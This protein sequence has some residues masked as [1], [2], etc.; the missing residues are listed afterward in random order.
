MPADTSDTS[1]GFVFSVGDVLWTVVGQFRA[2]EVGPQPFG[3]V[4]LGCISRQQYHL[5][6]VFGQELLNNLAAVGL[7]P[8]PNQDGLGVGE[9]TD[10]FLT[11]PE[12]AWKIVCFVDDLEGQLRRRA[13]PMVDQA[14]HH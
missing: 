1:A 8:I 6:A 13:V 12:D 4:Q 10:Q 14:A 7:Q 11:P 3:R 9:E 5:D 2:L